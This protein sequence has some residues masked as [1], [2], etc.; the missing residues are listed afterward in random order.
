MHAELVEHPTTPKSRCIGRLH[1][2]QRD[3]VATCRGV[4]SCDDDDKIAL[5][6]V[7]DECLGPTERVVL[8][9]AYRAGADVLE[10]GAGA[11]L[12]HG[13]GADQLASR[14]SWQPALALLIAAVGGQEVGHHSAVHQIAE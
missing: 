13:N 1:D 7:A 3:T 9:C 8:T 10:V 5:G 14:E 2:E 4:G 12:G 11:W 6:T